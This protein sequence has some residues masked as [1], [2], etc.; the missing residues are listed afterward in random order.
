MNNLRLALSLLFFI[1]I[2]SAAHA[3][4]YLDTIKAN[5]IKYNQLIIDKEID[6]ALDYTNP[7]FF[8]VIPRPQMLTLLN[9]VYQSVDIDFKMDLPVLSNFQAIKDI[10]GVKYVK[11]QSQSPIQMKF[12]SDTAR[13]T[14]DDINLQASLIKVSL[15]KQFGADNVS[16]NESTGYYNVKSIKPVVASKHTGSNKWTFVVLQKGQENVLAAFLPPELLN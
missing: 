9:K 13:K 16:Y 14:R 4:N 15:I 3:Q 8:K 5:F 12:K 11:F 1:C 6:K 7:D 2:C 10:K